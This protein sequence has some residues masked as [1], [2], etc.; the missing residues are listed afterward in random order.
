M[1]ITRK[2]ISLQ[3]EWGWSKELSRKNRQPIKGA[4][5]AKGGNAWSVWPPKEESHKSR[6]PRSGNK[7]PSFGASAL[8]TGGT[9][10]TSSSE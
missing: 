6:C 7:A 4:A 3:G 1:P 9:K 2:L 8:D 10:K 5:W